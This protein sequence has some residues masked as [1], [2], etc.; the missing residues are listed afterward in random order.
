MGGYDPAVPFRIKGRK[1]KLAITSADGRRHSRAAWSCAAV[2]APAYA[3]G[4][5]TA[6]R[7]GLA[8]RDER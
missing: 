7:T 3:G 2:V 6:G 4:Y 8:G 5:R 1:P